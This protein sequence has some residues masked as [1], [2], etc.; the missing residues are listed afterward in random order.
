[1]R[2]AL[3]TTIAFSIILV[4][5]NAQQPANPA[6]QDVIQTLSAAHEFEQTAISPDGKHVAWVETMPQ[7]GTAIYVSDLS[8]GSPR[9]MTAGAGPNYA[10]GNIAWS[11]DSKR[12]AFL[13]DAAKSGRQQL[14]I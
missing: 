11:P 13:S 4:T 2:K 12:I 3:T 10:E 1:M 14:Y 5:A 8:S 7:G 6:L 9:R